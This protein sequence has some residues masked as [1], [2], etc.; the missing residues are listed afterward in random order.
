M[1]PPDS[2]ILELLETTT[3]IAVVG[4][5]SNPD[6]SSHGVAARLQTAG[7]R[8]IPVNPNERAVLGVAAV[9]HLAA[10]G[11][12]VDIVDVFRR[13]EHTPAI[14]ADAVKI[15][16]RAL[17]LQSGVTDEEAARIARAGGLIVV[18]D[19]CLAVAVAR[20]RPRRRG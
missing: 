15:G 8:I 5:S 14:A 10:I 17:W 3:T 16:A 12:K 13:P 2:V 20:L 18:M 7:Y 11:E 6:R 19:A 9:P 4:L 1:N